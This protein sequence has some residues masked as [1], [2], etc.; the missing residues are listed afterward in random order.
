MG[1][2]KG[3]QDTMQVQTSRYLTSI[4]R[5]NASK[6]GIPIRSD[7]SVLLTHILNLPRFAKLPNPKAAIENIVQT[8]NKQRFSLFEDVGQLYIR[9]N[10][11]HSI[12]VRDLPLEKVTD[13]ARVPVA[14]HGTYR[15]KWELIIGK[16]DGV[17]SGMRYSANVYVYV[18][19]ARAIAD[20]IDFYVSENQVIL[21]SGDSDGY[22][23]PIYFSKVVD[24]DGNSLLELG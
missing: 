7:G 1:G 13:P 3:D 6:M 15:D 18:D 14:I 21:S 24:K 5:H 2:K 19:V 8:D 9:A 22:I 10:Q 11:G 4:L 23:Q 20:G 16:D 17:I 12:P